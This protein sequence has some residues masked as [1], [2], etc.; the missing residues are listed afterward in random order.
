MILHISSKNQ[1]YDLVKQ[2]RFKA[3]SSSRDN[4][5]VLDSAFSC[6][7][8]VLKEISKTLKLSHFHFFFFFFF[9]VLKNASNTLKL[10]SLTLFCYKN[11]LPNTLNWSHLHFF[12]IKNTSKYFILVSLTLSSV[13]IATVLSS[14]ENFGKSYTILLRICICTWRKSCGLWCLYMSLSN[15][16]LQISREKR[17]YIYINKSDVRNVVIYI[18]T[19]L[20]W[21][22][23]LYIYIYIYIKA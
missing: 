8:F 15:W 22:M 20:T 23:L 13:W 6:H 10:V 21:E 11:K 18:L 14:A 7:I 9:L 2:T 5:Q 1:G 4:S 17:C 3:E 12:V 16:D 19:N